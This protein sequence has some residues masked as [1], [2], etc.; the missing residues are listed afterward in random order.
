MRRSH[1]SG[2]QGLMLHLSTESVSLTSTLT[3]VPPRAAR[4]IP[5]CASR[6]FPFVSPYE[7]NRRNGA[8]RLAPAPERTA[9]LSGSLSA[10]SRYRRSEEHTSELQSR[11]DLVC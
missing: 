4:P 5:E 1:V 2:T 9:R 3:S 11:R 7:S 8:G 10:P 6:A